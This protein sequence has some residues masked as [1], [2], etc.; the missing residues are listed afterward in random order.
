MAPCALAQ[1]VIVS[2][3]QS[4]LP[5]LTRTQVEQFY[6]GRAHSLPDG[7]AVTLA[8][9]PASPLRDRFY[10]NLTGKN[11]GQIRAHWSRM[12][13]TGRALPPQE[14]ADIAQLRQW[15]NSIPNM[16]GYMPSAEA[17]SRVR[18]LLRLP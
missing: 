13:F 3:A 2:G 11:P 6:L 7:V 10:Q 16:I 12:V 1:I 4:P 9:L 15:L 14:A 18:V 8:D 5:E 17:D